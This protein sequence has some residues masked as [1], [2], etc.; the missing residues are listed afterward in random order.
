MTQKR[1]NCVNTAYG[2][3][4]SKEYD[5][6]RFSTPLESETRK[7]V[8]FWRNASYST[9]VGLAIVAFQSFRS[10]SINPQIS[11]L[12][13]LYTG[14]PVITTKIES[15]EELIKDG[16]TELLYSAE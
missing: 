1:D 2:H 16:Q 11:I 10:L 3:E 6:R 14:L 8:L 7:C 4:A 9:G 13:A 12:E 15:N 5:D